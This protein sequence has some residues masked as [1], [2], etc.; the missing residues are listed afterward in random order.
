MARFIQS[1]LEKKMIP[2]S[3]YVVE[4]QAFCVSYMKLKSVV[5]LFRLVSYKH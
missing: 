1:L 4:I 2:M 3:D 5:D